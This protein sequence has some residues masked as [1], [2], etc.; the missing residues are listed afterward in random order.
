MVLGPHQTL[1]Q[2]LVPA[3]V[4]GAFTAAIAIPVDA[5]FGP[6]TIRLLYTGNDVLPTPYSLLPAP[7]PCAWHPLHHRY[8]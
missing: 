8:P 5:P 7:T 3:A 4:F 2:A 1:S 6:K